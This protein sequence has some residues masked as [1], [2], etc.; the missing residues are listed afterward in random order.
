MY[1][2]EGLKLNKF[3]DVKIPANKDYFVR[4]GYTN[5]PASAYTGEDMAVR[6]KTKVDTFADMEAYDA[7]RQR[8]EDDLPND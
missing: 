3:K 4:Y 5:T 1:V 6:P 2:C 8:E 7:Q